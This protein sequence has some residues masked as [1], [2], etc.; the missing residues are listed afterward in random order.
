MGARR[1]LSALFTLGKSPRGAQRQSPN[2]LRLGRAGLGSTHVGFFHFTTAS[3]SAPAPS[4]LRFKDF[5]LS[6]SGLKEG[7]GGV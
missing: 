5:G 7:R 1:S 3:P 2:P 4:Y 6:S